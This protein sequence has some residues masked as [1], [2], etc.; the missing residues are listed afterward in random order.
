MLEKH[1]SY[2]LKKYMAAISQ[3]FEEFL[4]N[5]PPDLLPGTNLNIMRQDFYNIFK[6]DQ[7]SSKKYYKIITMGKL[8]RQPV[9]HSFILKR[10]DNDYRF[11]KFFK[12]GDIMLTDYYHHPFR[13]KAYGNIY[14]EYN[15]TWHKILPLDTNDDSL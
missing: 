8:F 11:N 3:N 2:Y 1:E 5:T 12:K 7:T 6:L 10:D 13:H 9:V 4:I 14:G 15:V